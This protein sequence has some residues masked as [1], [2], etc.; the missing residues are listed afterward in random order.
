MNRRD[1]W[2]IIVL[3]WASLTLPVYILGALFIGSWEGFVR[4]LDFENFAAMGVTDVIVAIVFLGPWAIIV[5]FLIKRII[6]Q[7]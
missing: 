2:R 3:S 1:L 6:V 4:A 5:G 7:K